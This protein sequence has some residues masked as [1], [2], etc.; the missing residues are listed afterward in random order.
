MGV[1]PGTLHLEAKLGNRSCAASLVVMVFCICS[2]DKENIPSLATVKPS[3]FM[4]IRYLCCK[5]A[6]DHEESLD[7]L[8]THR[9]R[10]RK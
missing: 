5:I 9:L 2:M 10:R 1:P 8:T 7:N 4:S 3:L 6:L